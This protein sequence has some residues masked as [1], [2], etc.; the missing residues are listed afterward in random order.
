[1]VANPFEQAIVTE[2]RRISA[3]VPGLNDEPLERL[4]RLVEDLAEAKEPPRN[5]RS[6]G[7]RLLVSPDPGYGKSHLIGRLFRRLEGR[8]TLVYLR[9]YAT[10]ASCWRSILLKTVQE[11]EF[12]E[13]QGLSPPESETQ[14]DAFIH[15]VLVN[16]ALNGLRRGVIA[17]RAP[18]RLIA[19]LERAAIAELRANDAWKKLLR[20]QTAKLSEL[21]K[22]QLYERGLQLTAS[23]AA[24]LRV[25]VCYAYEGRAQPELRQACLDWLKTACVDEEEGR[26]IGLS[27]ADRPPWDLSGE[28]AE[29]LARS[30]LADLV[31]LAGFFR[32]FVFC[33]DQTE[34]YASSPGLAASLGV[35]VEGLTAECPNQLTLLTANR[36][37]WEKGVLPHWQWAHKDRI[38]KPYLELKGINRSQAAEL[39][40]LRLEAAEA[41]GEIASRMLA[42]EFLE[43]FFAEYPE[44]NIRH[45]ISNCSLRFEELSR[46]DPAPRKPPDPEPQ[47]EEFYRARQEK[48]RT[49]PRRRVFNPDAL[50]WLLENAA[51]QGCTTFK[52]KSRYLVLGWEKAGKKVYFG[53]EAGHNGRRWQAIVKE[54]ESLEVADPGCKL[55][56]IRTPDL[57]PIPGARWKTALAIQAAR[58]KFLHLLT[59]DAEELSRL[60]AAH[61]LF[62]DAMEGDIPLAPEA[63]LAFV[64]QELQPFWERV[65]EPSPGNWAPPGSPP[66]PPAGQTGSSLKTRLRELLRREK[67]LSLQE[68]LE[69]IH[70]PATPAEIEK[71]RAAIPEI[72]VFDGPRMT[73]FQWRTGKRG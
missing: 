43:K 70:P 29:D 60:Y 32:P 59:L 58:G 73:V 1:M 10:A 44:V 12:P 39:V 66:E 37:P 68:I 56:F 13:R 15:G 53:L 49:Q 8:A 64:K 7:A 34:N 51:P 38:L 28:N 22:S 4:V 25:L 9:P 52:P 35:V 65:L 36:T 24:W 71:A 3:S 23:P 69:R 27:P 62:L 48:I 41:P 40:R 19:Y 61:D 30:R 26:A 46:H 11:M 21:L 57:R 47:L 54:G 42:Q 45:F 14:L 16:M 2:P 6:P 50:F 31:K 63:V 18:H 33:F 17:S 72:Q 67:F 55:V 5:A 20:Q